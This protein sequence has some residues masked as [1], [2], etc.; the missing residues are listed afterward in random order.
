MKATTPPVKDLTTSD[1][2]R[3]WALALRLLPLD[4]TDRPEILGVS[5]GGFFALPKSADLSP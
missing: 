3:L 1:P 2:N 5:Y 4:L